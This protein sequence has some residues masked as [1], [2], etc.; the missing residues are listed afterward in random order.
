MQRTHIIATKKSRRA[1]RHEFPPYV[2]SQVRELH[3]LDNYHGFLEVGRHWVAIALAILV[4]T[5]AFEAWG[6]ASMPIAVIAIVQ[7]GGR[8]RSLADVLHQSAHRSL[9]RSPFLN[10]ILGTYFSGYLVLQS[11]SGYRKSHVVGHHGSF[12]DPVLDPD[13]AALIEAGICGQN[14]TTEHALRYLLAI[15][16]VRSTVRYLKYLAKHRMRV[17]GESV[18]ETCR[19]IIFLFACVSIAAALGLLQELLVFW[20]IPYLTT[21]AWI[22]AVCELAEHYPMIDTENVIDIQ[23]TRNRHTSRLTC[24]LLGLTRTEGLHL[25]HHLFPKLPAWH[26]LKAHAILLLD[27]AYRANEAGRGHDWAQIF[28]EIVSAKLPSLESK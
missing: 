21:Q 3:Q 12:A 6:S 10:D 26:A 28:S 8:Q 23:A 17:S 11:L 19:R 2:R 20:V 1:A 16:T 13:Y 25:V 14:R 22:G 4:A 9:A 24:A 15:P 18:S 7:I 27:D 5:L